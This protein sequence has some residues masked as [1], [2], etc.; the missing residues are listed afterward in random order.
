MKKRIILG[1]F[2]LF[3]NIIFSQNL[4]SIE[5]TVQDSNSKPL[6]GVNVT[7]K[8]HSIGTQTDYNGLFK[9]KIPQGKQ[10][11]ELSYIGYKN[12]KIIV[13]NQTKTFKITLEESSIKLNSI[14]IHAKTNA[15]IIKGK[16]YEVDLL[17]TKGIKNS[18]I[19]INTALKGL[20]GIN[21]RQT[22]GLGSSFQFSMN[23]LSGKQV[24]FFIDG[25]PM[26]NLGTSMSLNNLPANLIERAEIYKG[27][28]PVE[29]GADA[30]GGAINIITKQQR[31]NYL[32][33]SYSAGSF[34]THTTSFLW[35]Y[36][37][38]KNG[39]ISKVSSF[40]NYSDNDYT[41]DNVNINDELGNTIGT[42]DNVKRFH[43]AYQSNM[44]NFKVG[45]LNKKFA[46]EL[47]VGG[48]F[49]GN[50]NEIQHALDPQKPYGGVLTKEKL[51]QASIIYKNKKILNNKLSVK[52]Y[53]SLTNRTSK[54]IDTISKIYY[55]Y[56]APVSVD[57]HISS[58]LKQGETSRYKSLF[59]LNDDSH[60]LN[61]TLNYKFTR[62]HNITFNYAK[63][64]L[65]RKGQDPFA[66]AR[67]PFSTPHT[68]DKN[69]LGLSYNFSLF[70]KSLKSSLFI[71]QYDLTT[72]GVIN[73]PLKSE[74]DP[75][76]YEEINT[77]F[78]K[79]GFGFA[80][81]YKL[82]NQ[83]RFK[84]SFEKALRLPEGYESFGNGNFLLPNI[85]LLPEESKNY[86]FGFIFNKKKS[87]NLN[88]NFN[89]NGFYRNAKN[90]IVLQAETIF[91]KYLNS[92]K[93]RI[94]GFETATSINY[95][96]WLVSFNVTKQDITE[97]N[98]NNKRVTIPNQPLFFGNS[99]L[100][101]NF[102]SIFNNHGSLTCTWSARYVDQYPLD[103]YVSGK[104]NARF[105]IPNQLS[106]S[107]EFNYSFSEKKYNI[108][109]LIN[110]ITD[111][112]L[113][114]NFRIQQPGRAYYVK[115]RYSL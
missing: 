46:D 100:A 32:D 90:L 73:A 81:T 75:T 19:N 66:R 83:I 72:K 104:P 109:F 61:S 8:N 36:Y 82:N 39:I 106:Q 37:N 15:E 71:K 92:S 50:K 53:G 91:S 103:S 64:Y 21:I 78:N 24:K 59:V 55:W 60:I 94:I 12:K 108:S 107:M 97:L 102:K 49:S 4:I 111:N 105:T 110:N 26:E 56:K 57:E 43:D 112:Q 18:S 115:L 114:D 84:T 51:K 16:A 58:N 79:I 99:R 23:G 1:L 20:S 63:S 41:I 89:I 35:Q 38:K 45:L 44:V 29:L 27:V 5:G 9:L 62:N 88:I 42:I 25:I 40:Y 54:F 33:V 7:I 76:K 34:N 85:L 65:E 10:E 31:N 14:E 86:N 101:Y 28:V 96:N 69:I 68:I 113:Y 2:L 17:D 6:L 77:S 70:E 13:N 48:T 87:N 52:L 11:L 80:T 93:A 22:G 30:L 98:N 74:S 3:N 67:V 95:K 47:F